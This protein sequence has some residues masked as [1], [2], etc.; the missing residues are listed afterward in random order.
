MSTT[1]SWS[2]GRSSLSS[3]SAIPSCLTSAPQ[4]P[5]TTFVAPSLFLLGVPPT[6]EHR[7]KMDGQGTLTLWFREN[8]DKDGNASDSVFGLTCCHVLRQET[9]TTYELR[10]GAPKYH[11]RVCRMRRFQDGLN[12]DIKLQRNIGHVQYAPSITVADSTGYSSD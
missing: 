8:R 11:V 1:W 12:T 7:E 2:F 3:W 4:T 6:V 5:P 10:S 9:T